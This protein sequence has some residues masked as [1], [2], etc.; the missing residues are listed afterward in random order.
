VVTNSSQGA[1]VNNFL[2][3]FHNNMEMALTSGS[4]DLEGGEEAIWIISL[5]SLKLKIKFF[6][7]STF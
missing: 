3:T 7:K 4:A 5:A 2:V 6:Y 1:M